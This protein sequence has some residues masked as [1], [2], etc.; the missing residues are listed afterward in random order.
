MISP[1][2]PIP[3]LILWC[4]Y[5][6]YKLNLV[7]PSLS[8][9]KAF[10]KSLAMSRYLSLLSLSFKF[11]MWSSGTTKSSIRQTLFFLLIIT[12]S[13]RLAEIRW[14]SCI[15]KFQRSLYVSLSRIDT[16]LRIYHFFVWSKFDFF[17]SSQWIT[18]PTRSCLVLYSFCASM[19]LSLIIRLTASSQ[20][21][22]NLHL[23]F[24]C[25]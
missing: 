22:H 4:G 2:P 24:C 13:G 9:P 6:E 21:P 8:F 16:W 14:S 19:L 23:L 25:V 1:C 18:L 15:S 7:S 3:V 12:W 5:Q 11:T 20:S 17:H 10:F